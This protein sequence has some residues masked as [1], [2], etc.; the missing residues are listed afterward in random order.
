[1]TLEDLRTASKSGHVLTTFTWSSPK[2]IS[3][4]LLKRNPGT[5]SRCM[6]QNRY[7]QGTGV[8]DR[9]ISLSGGANQP[10]G[11]VEFVYGLRWVGRFNLLQ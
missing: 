1:V 9:M 3:L 8:K 11:R 10:F 2:I 6:R 4:P 7:L 5:N